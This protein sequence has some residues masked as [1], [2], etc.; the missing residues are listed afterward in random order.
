G[1]ASQLNE[2]Y[3]KHRTIGLPFV[4]AKWAMT[5]DGRIATR[6]GD[7][8]W[9]SG[10]ASRALAHDVRAA[11]DAILVG[12]GT[13]L[14]DDP[15]LTARGAAATAPWSRPGAWTRCGGSSPRCWSAVRGRVL[16]VG[17]AW[18][19]WPGPGGSRGPS[20]A[21]WNRTWSSRGTS[22]R[23]RGIRS[24][25]RAGLGRVARNVYRHRRGDRGRAGGPAGRRV[26]A[27][28]R[29][30]PMRPR[31]CARGR[32]H[33]GQRDVSDGDAERRQPL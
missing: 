23:R 24:P 20:S 26:A 25:A 3:I 8:R 15:R 33:R 13:V 10:A 2:A 22:S 4:T 18:R 6:A 9:I 32:P 14:R 19:R 12:I 7:S 29:R 5:L 17:R 16:W 28:E 1:G 31:G 30:G 21:R 27:G 11:S